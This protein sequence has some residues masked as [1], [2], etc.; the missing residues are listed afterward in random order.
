MYSSSPKFRISFIILT[1]YMSGCGGGGGGSTKTEVKPT[2][3]PTVDHGPIAPPQLSIVPQNPQKKV[4]IGIIDSGVNLQ[5]EQLKGQIA[6]VLKANENFSKDQLTLIDIS[7]QQPHQLDMSV[8]HH[9]TLLAQIIAGSGSDHNAKGLAHD[10]AEIYAAQTTL[11]S[12]G[13]AYVQTNFRTMRELQQQYDVNLFNA[14]F[15]SQNN[16]IAENSKSF[17]YAKQ[18]IENG[19]LLVLAAGNQAQ[20][21]PSNES[22][23]PLSE[24]SLEAG[25]LTVTGLDQ[26]RRELYRES[27]TVGANE[28]G[29]A[30]RWCLAAD[31][32]NGPYQ[33]SDEQKKGYF[34]GTSGSAPQVTALAAKVWSKYPWLSANQVKQVILTTADYIENGENTGSYNSTYGWGYINVDDALKGP[35]RFSRLFDTNFK[36]NVSKQIESTFSNDIQGDAG[37]VKSGAGTLILTG[38]NSYTGKTIINNGTLYVDGSLQTATEILTHGVLAGKGSVADVQN[39]GILSTQRGMLKIN[40]DYQQTPEG[41]FRLELKKPLQIRGNAIVDGTLEVDAQD[42]NTI[43][44][45]QYTVL[46]ATEGVSGSFD[47]V[48]AINPFLKI[49]DVVYY[50]SHIEL[51]INTNPNPST[52]QQNAQK[53]QLANDLTYALL[54]K[55][56]KS[57]E[58]QYLNDYATSVLQASSNNKLDEV[59]QSHNAKWLFDTPNVLMQQDSLNQVQM[60]RYLSQAGTASNVWLNSS[61]LSGHK[62]THDA[63]LSTFMTGADRH[64]LRDFKLG[65]HAQYSQN[66]LNFGQA[67]TKGDSNLYQWGAYGTWHGQAFYSTHQFYQGRG[68]LDFERH[69]LNREVTDSQADLNQYG[70][71]S[72]LGYRFQQ[73]NWKLS[74]Y[75]G[76]SYQKLE[77]TGIQEASQAG[78]VTD[79]QKYSQ[80]QAHFGGRVE[81]T[82]QRPWGFNGFMGYISPFSQQGGKVKVTSLL[83]PSIQADK[84]IDLDSQKWWFYGLGVHYKSVQRPWRLQSEWTGSDQFD[85]QIKLGL[86]YQF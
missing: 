77:M 22:L 34:K 26:N 86:E 65:L 40:G 81:T 9:G 25:F 24:P 50:P 31:Y 57:P 18:L 6:K 85:Y 69:L 74:P 3:L 27:A 41:T 51:S 71:Y 72:E 36:A 84:V 55:A 17:F 80:Y 54:E 48:A 2:P 21:N 82:W 60:A 44:K 32:I 75:V 12:Y 7:D 68:Q 62:N 73:P 42:I 63:D 76:L 16:T 83:D 39:A 59:L 70:T 23:M 49:E 30:A 37:L 38:K 11:D 19:G 58:N 8:E 45:G 35:E 46:D 52:T 61:D 5:H 47:K 64:F 53:N 4:A 33:A 43:R 79:S 20:K 1:L 29:A 14:S 15:G 56:K 28:C 10:V 13:S 66:T 78:I 67:Q